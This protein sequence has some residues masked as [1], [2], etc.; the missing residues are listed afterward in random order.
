MTGPLRATAGWLA[1][2]STLPTA[3]R[4]VF[5][6]YGHTGQFDLASLRLKS[7]VDDRTEAMVEDVFTSVESAL[8]R[9]FDVESVTFEYDTKLLL[10][11]ELTLGYL[12]RRA[13]R[14]ADGF[15]PVAESTWASRVDDAVGSEAYRAP[16]D[17]DEWEGSSDDPRELVDRAEYLT[18][19]VIGALLDGDMRDAVNDAE[20]E[21]F[22]VSLAVDREERARVA[23]VAQKTLQ[24]DLEDR[25]EALPDELTESYEWAVELS[26]AH[27]DRDPHFRDLYERARDG[28][29]DARTTIEAE[30]RDAPFDA[31]TDVFTG[32][33]RDLPYL[34]TQYARVG[35]IYDAMIEMYRA[36][37]LPVETAF[38]RSIV[39]SIVAAQIWLDDVDDYGADVE[40]GQLTPVTAEYLLAEGDREA[41]RRVRDLTEQYLDLARTYAAETESPLTGIATEYIY[42]SGNPHVLPGTD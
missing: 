9:E 27:Q 26:E 7:T 18:R 24:T 10:P 31:D 30:Y 25:L 12:Y 1:R 21:D 39:L 16:A 42:L 35:V 36:A 4:A 29:G 17:P 32:E 3:V 11:A 41:A 34:W 40:D 22:E 13:Q 19:V 38:K 6:Y 37:G 8:A 2:R 23:R 14:R 5:S 33:E 20:Y 15:D 28:D